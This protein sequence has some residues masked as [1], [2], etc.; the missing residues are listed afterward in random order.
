MVP[1]LVQI[2]YGDNHGL[3]KQ[4]LQQERPFDTQLFQLGCVENV[5]GRCNSGFEEPRVEEE[6]IKEYRTTLDVLTPGSWT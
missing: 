6:P 3:Q 2:V 1:K 4:G 5:E